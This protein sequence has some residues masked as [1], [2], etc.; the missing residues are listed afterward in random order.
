[1]NGS[2]RRET[3]KKESKVKSPTRKPGVLGT[4]SRLGFIV[5]ATRPSCSQVIHRKILRNPHKTSLSPSYPQNVTVISLNVLSS[6]SFLELEE[7]GTHESHIKKNSSP[8]FL[9]SSKPSSLQSPRAGDEKHKNDFND[10]SFEQL[11]EEALAENLDQF[12]YIAKALLKI[13]QGE[14]K[15]TSIV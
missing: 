9:T 15:P 4:R 12:S 10:L 8:N 7:I 13:R 3:S 5:R 6:L 14:G 11:L 1:M 2:G